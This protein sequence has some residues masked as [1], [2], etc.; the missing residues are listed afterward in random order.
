MSAEKHS[1]MASNRRDLLLD[2]DEEDDSDLYLVARRH[3]RS[4]KQYFSRPL[5]LSRTLPVSIGFVLGPWSYLSK[6]VA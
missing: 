2:R 3:T 6:V 5:L 4:Y 1:E